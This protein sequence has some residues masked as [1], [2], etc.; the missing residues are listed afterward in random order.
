M[1]DCSFLSHV[2]FSPT[3]VALKT[4]SKKTNNCSS[5][6]TMAVISVG[7][8]EA[9]VIQC[10][11]VNPRCDFW[12]E[13]CLHDDIC[14][15]AEC[16]KALN[17]KCKNLKWCKDGE[18]KVNLKGYNIHLFVIP[19]ET[20]PPID[21]LN[22]IAKVICEGV[23]SNPLNCNNLLLDADNLF[24]LG[25]NTRWQDIPS[26]EDCLACPFK[27]TGQS[28]SDSWFGKNCRRVNSF[29][30]LGCINK[31]LARY[32][33]APNSITCGHFKQESTDKKHDDISV[34]E[35]NEDNDSKMVHKHVDKKQSY[36]PK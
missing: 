29:F 12:Q 30:A 25:T 15:K 6:V 22:N 20:V 33:Q 13:K 36:Q 8:D 28:N 5:N 34:D 9:A 31:N 27:T 1:I 4:A 32:L 26:T 3:E 23:N 19:F 14:D 2:K 24:W 17:F 10:D 21:T 18:E 16:A 35:E 11:P 7:D